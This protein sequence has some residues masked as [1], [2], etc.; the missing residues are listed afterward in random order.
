[1]VG[2]IF[3]LVCS[4]FGGVSNVGLRRGAL[5]GLALQGLVITV[6]TG[7]PLFFVAAL[8]SGQIFRYQ[9]ISPTNYLILALAGAIHYVIGRYTIIRAVDAIGT[10]RA[11]PALQL[12]TL[13]SVMAAILFLSETVTLLMSGGIALVVVGPLIALHKP[14]QSDNSDEPRPRLLAGYTWCVINSLAFGISPVL[15]RHVLEDSGSG[16]GILGGLVAYV[17]GAILLLPVILSPSRLRGIVRMDKTSQRW[18]LFAALT[19]FLGHMFYFLALSQSP[20]SVVI[21]LMQSRAIFSL[22]FAFVLSRQVE[23]FSPKVLSGI[24]IS[25]VGAISLVW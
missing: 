21:P 14:S 8:V 11:T 4:A 7:V 6:L 22:I 2:I 3:A 13:V 5:T 12:S 23:S 24:A 9:S 1:V 25:V 10:I 19:L 15:I 20:V 17:A 16:L 18:F